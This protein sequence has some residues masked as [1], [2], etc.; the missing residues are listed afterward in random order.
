MLQACSA[1][2]RAGAVG[3]HFLGAAIHTRITQTS[4]LSPV[5]LTLGKR[6]G[7]G[8]RP[9]S[10]CDT[11]NL[12]SKSRVL[13]KVGRNT[14]S[15]PIVAA[16]S[17]LES[18]AQVGTN[19]QL[20]EAPRLMIVS[21]LDFT[22]IDH[23]D[24]DHAS[25]FRF[26]SL[27]GAE[28]ATNSLLVYST[29]RSPQ[30]FL[31]VMK[32]VPLYTPDIVIMS[33]GTEIMYG[34]TMT[35]DDGWE[36]FLNDGWNRDVVE[37]SEQRPHKISFFIDKDKAQEA[38]D[39]LSHRL[40]ERGLKFNIIY[41]GGSA[42]DVLSHRAGKGKALEYLLQKLGEEGK[43]PLHTLACGDSGND[44]ELFTVDGANGVIVGNAMEELVSWHASRDAGS[45]AHIFRATERCA[46]GI[47]QA[48]RHFRFLAS[49]SPRDDVRAFLA[50]DA[51]APAGEAGDAPSGEAGAR[52]TAQGAQQ[53]A[54][55]G[56]GGR[57]GL[58]AAVAAAD[59]QREVVRVF[60]GIEKWLLGDVENSDET[61]ALLFENVFADDIALVK[62]SGVQ[63]SK[64]VAGPHFRA[65]HGKARGSNLRVW[66]DRLRVR[67]LAADAWLASFFA[68]FAFPD[69]REV[70]IF[71]AVLQKKAGNPSGLEWVHLHE[72]YLEGYGPQ[73]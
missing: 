61:L 18:A 9:G 72:S 52:E 3:L 8:L 41:S 45:T 42:V 2:V 21:D 56:Q 33:V 49:P 64:A 34:Q 60:L 5:S 26:T 28:Y 14:F 63:Q 23:H 15:S 37:E 27:W 71:S 19:V 12:R 39:G 20:S 65:Q 68:T 13:K 6:A 73:G 59:V 29:G 43:R 36:H 48:M 57:G 47:L 1:S 50:G 17:T 66:V 69:R 46:S 30:K 67:Q 24:H 54:P 4:A 35:P 53:G 62:A 11:N 70:V 38:I 25:L 32:E 7:L 51:P 31:Q 40:R 10:Q 22:M 16:M 44:I 58:A 55:G